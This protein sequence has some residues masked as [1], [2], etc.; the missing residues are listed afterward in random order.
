MQFLYLQKFYAEFSKKNVFAY[1]T[2]VINGRVMI[3]ILN[4]SAWHSLQDNVTIFCDF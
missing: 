2:F 4:E 3:D 1:S